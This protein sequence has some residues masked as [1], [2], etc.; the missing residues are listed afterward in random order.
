MMIKSGSIYSSM[1]ILYISMNSEK[2][3]ARD[4]VMVVDCPKG[5]TLSRSDGTIPTPIKIM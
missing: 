2:M 4:I 5:F 3:V 1:G